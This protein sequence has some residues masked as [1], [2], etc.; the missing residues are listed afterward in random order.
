M[1][2]EH[3]AA[4]FAKKLPSKRERRTRQG[5]LKGDRPSSWNDGAAFHRDGEDFRGASWGAGL[6]VSTNISLV[7]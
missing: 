1:L 3:R 5:S 7:Q 6:E 4:E 2:F